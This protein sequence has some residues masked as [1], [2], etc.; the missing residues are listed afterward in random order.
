VLGAGVALGVVA[1]LGDLGKTKT[2]VTEQ[3]EAQASIVS[4][5]G[6]KGLTIPEIYERTAPGVVQV[7][8]TSSSQSSPFLPAQQQAALGSGFVIDKQGHIVT[9]Y[10]VVQ[11]A[12]SIDVSFAN[13]VS[14]AATVVGTDKS[15]DLA[16][17]KVKVS[18]SALTPLPLGDSSVVEVGDTVVA[19]GNPFVD[20]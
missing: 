11:G 19:I 8:S 16:V 15:T 17:L 13:N 1:G 9:N 18:S 10:H 20:R 4:Q 14:A 7:T 5:G 2:V 6:G 12:D 3:V